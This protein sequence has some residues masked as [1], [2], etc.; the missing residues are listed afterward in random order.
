MINSVLFYMKIKKKHKA[1]LEIKLAVI[2]KKQT[3]IK[4]II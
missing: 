4:L 3:K 1:K 2:C